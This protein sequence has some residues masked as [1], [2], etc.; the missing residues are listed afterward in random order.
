MAKSGSAFKAA[1]VD[2]DLNGAGEVRCDH[3]L[4]SLFVTASAFHLND[5]KQS[6]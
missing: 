2:Q 4:T 6:T 1:T 3:P 5:Y